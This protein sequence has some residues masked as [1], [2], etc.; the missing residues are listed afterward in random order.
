MSAVF[1]Y[2][3]AFYVHAF[4]G[5]LLGFIVL[6]FGFKERPL[7]F[8]LTVAAFLFVA[9]VSLT[10]AT[11]IYEE[12]SYFGS[13][14][15][16]HLADDDAHLLYHG[17][18]IHGIQMLA[19]ARRTEAVSYYSSDGPIGQVFSA[20]RTERDRL[21]VG[22]VGL[23]IGSALCYAEPGDTW[24]VFEIDPL[25]VELARDTRFFHQWRECGGRVDPTLSIGDAR[26]RLR[27]SSSEFDLMILDAYSSDAIPIHLITREA[28][29][30]Y[31][32]RLR[33]GG[34]LLFHISNRH[35]KLDEVLSALTTDMGLAA[36]V[37]RHKLNSSASRVMLDS[38]WVAVAES[39]GDLGM[40][41]IS[42][43]WHDLVPTEIAPWT[44]DYSNILGVLR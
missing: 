17:T 6:G 37:Q 19:P 36:L 5:I 22:L 30:L 29:D 11:V 8:G 32:E 39:S 34:I 26:V 16:A 10:D 7:R 31:R 12:R 27:E 1:T 3:P 41:A 14:R 43:A 38:V 9:S 35:L 40:L 23:G 28:L 15:V 25:V 20:L 13:Y 18:T 33:P 21:Q 42:V 24:Q 44:D 2:S 4:I